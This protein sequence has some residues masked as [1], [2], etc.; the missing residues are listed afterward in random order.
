MKIYKN[1]FSVLFF[2]IMVSALIYF[3]VSLKNNFKVEIRSISIEG[4]NYLSKENYLSFA[5]LLNKNEYKNLTL[6]I[7]KDRIEKHPYVLKADVRYEGN[8]KVH[9]IIY[10]KN[11]DAILLDK[12]NQY[13]ITDKMQVLPILENTKNIDYPVITNVYLQ[14]SIKVL[15]SI[16]KNVDVLT[17]AKIISAVKFANPE[18]YNFLSTI[19]LQYGGEISIYFSDLNYYLLIGRENEVKRV[20][21]FSSLWNILKGKE[22]NNYMEYVD[23]R[24]GGHIFLGINELNQEAEKE[25]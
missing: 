8:Y 3:S 25:S 11:I 16:K 6:R 21:Y 18:L 7:I 23:L 15:S 19:D 10:E 1:I 2:F 22:I 12:E 24:Y 9:I 17:A 5:H 4:S 20:L 13:L 14:D